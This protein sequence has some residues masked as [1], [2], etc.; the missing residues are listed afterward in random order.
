[1][2]IIRARIS[3]HRVHEIL[4]R[5]AGRGITNSPV[6]T[7]EVWGQTYS[8]EGSIF[9]WAVFLHVGGAQ[10]KVF[11]SSQSDSVGVTWEPRRKPG[12]GASEYFR[13][14]AH[15]EL[16]AERLAKRIAEELAQEIIYEEEE[17]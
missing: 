8:T 6:R 1:M 11:K 14:T 9:L 7:G 13:P 2:E 4:E 15:E 12:S 3:K 5:F 10:V 16:I 17:V